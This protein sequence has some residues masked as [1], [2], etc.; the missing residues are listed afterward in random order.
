MRVLPAISRALWRPRAVETCSVKN[1]A[2]ITRSNGAGPYPKAK[3]M[4]L[5]NGL[6]STAGGTNRNT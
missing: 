5:N 2:M 4:T 1:G 6:A 3:Q